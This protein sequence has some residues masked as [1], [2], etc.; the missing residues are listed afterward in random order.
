MNVWCSLPAR[1][2]YREAFS[3][4]DKPDRRPELGKITV[5]TLLIH[6][7]LDAPI[8]FAEAEEMSNLFPNSRLSPI[9]GA[10]HTSNLEHPDL[11]SAEI[12]AFLRTI[13]G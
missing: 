13:Y 2:V 6:G 9:P 1:S 12:L 10:G 4:L 5:P 7:E 3:W 8:P 11:V